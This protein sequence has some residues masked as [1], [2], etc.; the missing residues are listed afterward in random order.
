MI[1][2]VSRTTLEAIAQFFRLESAGGLLLVAAA[3]LAVVV[4]NSPLAPFYDAALTTRLTITLGG[5]GLDKPI[6]LWV[7][8]GL[9]AVFFL[10]VGLEL[11]REILEGQLSS[12]DQVVLPALAALGGLAV[13]AL[14]YW[15]LNHGGGQALNGWAIPTATDIAFALAVLSLLGK[16]VPLSLKVFLTTI[17]IVDDLAAI[18]IIAVFYSGD[19]SLAALLGAGFGVVILALLNRFRVQR[20]AAYILVGIVTWF[21]VL[22][23]GVHATLAGVAVAAFIPL[24]AR[25]QESPARHLEHTLHPWVAFAIL[26]LFAFANAG[27]SLH[28]VGANLL[29]GGVSLGIVLGL[30]LGKQLGVFGMTVMATGLGLAR[31]PEGTTLGQLYAV[32]VVCGVGFTMSLFIGSLAFEHGDFALDAA[33]KVGVTTGSLL[34]AGLGLLLLHLTLPKTPVTQAASSQLD[35]E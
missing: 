33:V 18:L 4:A 29:T 15:G 8:D 13:P 9:M 16:R 25:D 24:R 26:P 14:F 1:K 20:L 22:K 27:V 5:Y 6:L 3:L 19:L 31:R 12:A 17:A 34:S 35:D 7:N 21:C 28:G 11:K 30:F 32:S 23:S 10:L 2:S